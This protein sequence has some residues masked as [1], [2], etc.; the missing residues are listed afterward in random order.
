MKGVFKKF[1]C[2]PHGCA[3][4]PTLLLRSNIQYVYSRFLVGP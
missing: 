2:L 4:T 1:A 3:C